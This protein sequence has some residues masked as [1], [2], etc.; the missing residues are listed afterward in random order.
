[1]INSKTKLF[2]SFSSKPGNV[3][4]RLF[5]TAFKYY[6]YD[7]IYKSYKSVDIEASIN[8]ART[9]GFSG[10]A[11]SMPFKKKAIEYIDYLDDAA[12]DIGAINTVVDR[13]EGCSLLWGYNTDFFA[14][15]QVLKESGRKRVY[16]LGNGGYS[17]AVQCAAKSLDMIYY[18]ITR[19]NWD[20]IQDLRSQLIYNCTPVENVERDPSNTFIDCI[21][22]TSTGKRLA[23]LQA[24]KQFELYT[25][26]EFPFSL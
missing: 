26:L 24:S 14:A 9:L 3:G 10:F 11:I 7:A 25:G 4:C 8:A 13:G 2:G 20:K 23:T 5:N 15:Q 19:D 18:L 17:A 6:D 1:M 12:A 16:I 22:T 21:N